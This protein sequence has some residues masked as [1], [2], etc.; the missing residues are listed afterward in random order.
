[1]WPFLNRS[2]SN[3]PPGVPR[4]PLKFARLVDEMGGF[5]DLADHDCALKFWLPEPAAEALLEFSDLGGYSM[6]EALRQFLAQHCY[7]VYA[8][9][10]MN[11][12][13]P[14]LFRDPEPPMFSRKEAAN[15][16]REKKREP[17][18]W[19]PEL[20]K[21]IAAIKV[22]IPHRLRDDLSRL[23]AH[24]G[25]PLSQYVREI[26]ISRLLGHGALP[27]RKE[28]ME[29]IPQSSAEDWCAGREV[30]MRQVDP[31]VFELHADGEIRT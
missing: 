27:K 10:V 13:L 7:G 9:Q 15:S 3:E 16:R 29:A 21:N 25:L 6:S 12:A 8:F 17:T 14:G 1:M 23:A 24:V 26:T 18:Y 4:K 20:G 28:M 11:D 30:P 5:S 2:N 19:V 31:T 22:W